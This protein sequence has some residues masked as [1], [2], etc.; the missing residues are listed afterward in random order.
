MGIGTWLGVAD[1][2][3][4][5]RW[6][7]RHLPADP[8]DVCASPSDVEGRTFIVTGPT[9][10]I[11]TTTA[12]TLAKMGAHVILACR[13]TAK[14]QAL[15][16]GWVAEGRAAPLRC[17]VMHLD[18][19]SLD[20]VRA[21]CAQF[22][23]RGEPCHCL[24]NNAGVFDM[25]GAHTSTSDGHE[26]HYGTNY[27]APALL[28]LLLMPSLRRAGTPGAPARVVFVCSK[29][30]EFCDELQLDDLN[31]ARRRYSA[32][33]AYAQSKLAELLFV[34]ELERRMGVQ[35][36]KPAAS[37]AAAATAAADTAVDDEEKDEGEDSAARSQA[38]SLGEWGGVTGSGGTNG[39]T[40]RNSSTKK[41]DRARCHVR[42][43]AVHPGNVVTGVVRTLPRLVQ[44]AYKV[45]M[46]A[47][48]L[49]PREGARASLYAATRWGGRQLAPRT[50]YPGCELARTSTPTLYA[51]IRL[52]L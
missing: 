33:A 45:V 42:A 2:V 5:Q 51:A 17:E 36:E 21:F 22:N 48:L 34:R 10:G 35:D 9:S 20:S 3:L 11:G 6:H 31:F 13:T 46:G 1:D 24:V 4:L 28:A 49:T 50:L 29:L 47:I 38:P 27:L 16:D 52:R 43:M 26:T 8:G 40:S 14:G 23:A 15:V 12:E 44:V 19:D 25:S 41:V 7:T 37:A 30:H 32:R 39:R 18:L